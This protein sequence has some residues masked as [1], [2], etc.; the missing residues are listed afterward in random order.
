MQILKH[1]PHEMGPFSLSIGIRCFSD[2]GY[3]FSRASPYYAI[4]E[5]A[6]IEDED[7]KKSA[8]RHFVRFDPITMAVSDAGFESASGPS[9]VVDEAL[10]NGQLKTAK[11]VPEGTHSPA[12]RFQ[13]IAC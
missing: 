1:A 10:T 8:L 11:C 7:E 13:R 2:D 5:P 3:I 12:N 9:D 6:K 4:Q